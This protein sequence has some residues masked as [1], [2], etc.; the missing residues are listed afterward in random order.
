MNWP[1][2]ALIALLVG[3]TLCF[4]QANEC[5]A[6]KEKPMTYSQAANLLSQ[7]LAVRVPATRQ[8]LSKEERF[9]LRA[10]LL[11]ERGIRVLKNS[12]PDT[13]VTLSDL[14]HI[15]YDAILGPNNATAKQKIDYLGQM[16]Y[17]GNNRQKKNNTAMD[18]REIIN[19]FR[20]PELT[21]AVLKA[22]G[23]AKTRKS[24]GL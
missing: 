23:P 18:Y 21:K 6:A 20:V 19:M 3:S 11:A 16:G 1:R 24:V 13:V 12:T 7:L 14:A 17:L 2:T 5:L 8:K 22:Y 15:F 9:T 4:V 10:Q